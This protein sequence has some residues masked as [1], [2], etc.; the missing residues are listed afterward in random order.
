MIC[1]WHCDCTNS[2]VVTIKGHEIH[3]DSPDVAVLCRRRFRTSRRAIQSTLGSGTSRPSAACHIR[4]VGKR[5]APGRRFIRYIYLCQGRTS[6]LG[7]RAGISASPARRC[8][9]RLPQGKAGSQESCNRHGKARLIV[10]RTDSP[11]LRGA[12]VVTSSTWPPFRMHK[13]VPG[14]SA[15][16]KSALSK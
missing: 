2:W 6:A 15:S 9:A 11:H 1:S 3:I 12:R 14:S 5:A 4:T 10:S 16:H 13:T 8:G 7:I